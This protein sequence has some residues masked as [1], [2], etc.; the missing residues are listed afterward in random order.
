MRTVSVV[1]ISLLLMVS[2]GDPAMAAADPAREESSISTEFRL[3]DDRAADA[4][5]PES[6]IT[7]TQRR[8]GTQQDGS[9]T[10]SSAPNPSAA[11][12][13]LPSALRT[14]HARNAVLRC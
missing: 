2:G 7:G 10:P 1:L 12:R 6:V 9:A 14:H 13:G 5:P 4:V 3:S 11:P 8:C